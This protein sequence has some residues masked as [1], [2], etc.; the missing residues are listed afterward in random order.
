MRFSEVLFKDSVPGA[1][2]SQIESYLG[3]VVLNI[4]GKMKHSNWRDE[5]SVVLKT[6]TTVI[7]NVSD[8]VVEVKKIPNSC[9][10]LV[11]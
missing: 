4:E 3:F 1:L 11:R 7:P 6:S 2:V 10:R 5:A 9:S 8:I